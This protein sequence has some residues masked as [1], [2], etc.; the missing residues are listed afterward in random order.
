ML[1]VLDSNI[2]VQK[3]L[4]DPYCDTMTGVPFSEEYLWGKHGFGNCLQIS[5]YHLQRVPADQQVPYSVQDLLFEEFTLATTHRRSPGINSSVFSAADGD[6]E[7]PELLFVEEAV[8]DEQ[9]D[10]ENQ[11]PEVPESF[12]LKDAIKSITMEFMTEVS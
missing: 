3:K 12:L 5:S 10:P 7:V 4:E 8:I 2:S 9:I 1:S 11:F 6:A